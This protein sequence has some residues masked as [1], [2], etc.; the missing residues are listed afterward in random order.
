MRRTKVFEWEPKTQ[1]IKMRNF[2]INLERRPERW[3]Y[4]RN[5]FHKLGIDVERFI[6]YDIKPGW[7]GCSKSHLEIMRLCKDENMFGIYEDD[8]KILRGLSVLHRAFEQLPEDWD[9][10]YLG[11]SP[12][13]QQERI[14]ENLFRLN[15]AHVTH[16]IIWRNRTG[17][18]VKHI[19]SHEHHIKKYDDYLATVIQPKFNCFVTYPMVATQIQFQSDTCTR[20]DVSTIEKNYNLYCQ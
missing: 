15:N 8:V 11:A 19:L 14:S 17:G 2:C 13:Q 18:A 1:G 12:K 20:S 7:V 16:A 3:R 6:A 4:V 10:L 5:E 9:C